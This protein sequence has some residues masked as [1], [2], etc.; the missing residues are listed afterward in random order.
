LRSSA[1]ASATA[2]VATLE[3]YLSERENVRAA[4]RRLGVAPRTVAYRLERIG[5]ILVGPLDP[6]RRLRLAA[7]LFARTLLAPEP[8][9][10][11]RGG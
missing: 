4:A 2:L 9:Q 11:G 3:A 10:P 8:R 5:R 6:A 7:A 1:K